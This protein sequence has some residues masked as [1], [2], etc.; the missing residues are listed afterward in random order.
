MGRPIDILFDFAAAHVIGEAAAS[1][2]LRIDYTFTDYG[3]T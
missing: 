1:A 3:Q 2:D